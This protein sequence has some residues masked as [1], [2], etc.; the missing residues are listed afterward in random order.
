MPLTKKGS[1]IMGAMKKEYGEKKGEQVFYASQNKG[2]IT[3]THKTKR[4]SK[5]LK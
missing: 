5:V 2:T 3:G 4:K 1:K